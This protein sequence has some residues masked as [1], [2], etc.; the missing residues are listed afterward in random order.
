MSC[1]V[2]FSGSYSNTWN[3]VVTNT[4]GTTWTGTAVDTATNAQQHIGTYTLPSDAGGIQNSQLGFVEYYPWNS[5][6]SLTCADLP[7]TE[8]TF[9]PPTTESSSVGAQTGTLSGSVDKC[10]SYIT[11]E[12]VS[13]GVDFII[14]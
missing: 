2:E 14:S 5:D 3:L 6:P 13:G 11:Q 12:S 9:Y 7:S 10:Q 1:A 4:G 8:G